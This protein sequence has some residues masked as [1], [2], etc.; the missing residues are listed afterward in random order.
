VS[1]GY[2]A[3]PFPTQ[4]QVPRVAPSSTYMHKMLVSRWSRKSI[5]ARSLI[6]SSSAKVVSAD[7]QFYPTKMVKA[8]QDKAAAGIFNMVDTKTGTLPVAAVMSCCDCHAAD[9]VLVLLLTVQNQ[10]LACN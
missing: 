3:A 6:H 10:G 5:Y 7:Y 8:N 1:G 4:E 2:L 9:V